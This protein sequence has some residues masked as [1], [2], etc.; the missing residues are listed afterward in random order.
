MSIRED[1]RVILYEHPFNERIRTYLRLEHLFLRLDE[2]LQREAATDH[3]F[4]LL[5]LFELMDVAARSD[6]RSEIQKDLDR[7]RGEME[8]YRGNP[9]IAQQVLESTVEHLQAIGRA[10]ARQDGKP[11]HE[12]AENDWLASIR[13][14]VSIP[15]G[16]CGFDL[17]GYHAWQHQPAALRRSQLQQWAA[18]FAPL[19]QAVSTLLKILRDTG[20]PRKAEASGGQFQMSLPQG[21]TIQLLRLRLDPALDVVP[22]ISGNRMLVSIRLMQYG[23]DGRHALAPVDAAFELSLCS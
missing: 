13:N 12:L 21:R 15:G 10:F 1:P 17:P 6:L 7:K 9:A 18:S 14:R 19:M 5:T 20:T 8:S 2:L 16:T 23:T 22:E 3:H 4:A 11:G